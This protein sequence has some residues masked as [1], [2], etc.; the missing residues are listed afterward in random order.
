MAAESL[1][2]NRYVETK[3]SFYQI[4]DSYISHALSHNEAISHW[5]QSKDTEQR[6]EDWV[7]RNNET[8][9]KDITKLKEI[10]LNEKDK[11]I[12]IN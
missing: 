2:V 9:Y 4:L 3:S 8:F 12:S 6:V 10:V 5:I 1:W 11:I 7:S